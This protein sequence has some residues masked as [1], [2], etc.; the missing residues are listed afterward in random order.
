MLRP[1]ANYLEVVWV[2][3]RITPDTPPKVYTFKDNLKHPRCLGNFLPTESGSRDATFCFDSRR[4]SGCALD[5]LLYFAHLCCWKVV[6]QEHGPVSNLNLLK[7]AQ[8]TQSIFPLTPINVPQTPAPFPVAA[9]SPGLRSLLSRAGNGLPIV[10]RTLKEPSLNCLL[11]GICTSFPVELQ[12]DV[13]CCLSDGLTYALL[14]ASPT[15]NSFFGHVNQSLTSGKVTRSLLP[16]G[17]GVGWLRGS[18]ITM[19]GQ[20]Y[21]HRVWFSENAEGEASNSC[22]PIQRNTVRGINFVVG[23]Y[24][25]RAIRVINRDGAV[26]AWLGSPSKGWHGTTSGD[27]P[28]LLRVTQDV[29]TYLAANE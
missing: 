2:P 7:L 12:Q 28:R 25:L 15:A 22:I 16:E 3:P 4:D 26:S 19:F 14:G 11:L 13:L 1:C 23:I 9:Q 5:N 29:S 17:P 20:E 24:G 8:Q 18:T 6:R 21:L 27:D 10:P